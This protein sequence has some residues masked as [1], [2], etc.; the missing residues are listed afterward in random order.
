MNLWPAMSMEKVIM[1][2]CI[3]DDNYS[4]S[5]ESDSE[6]SDSHN[7]YNLDTS[8]FRMSKPGKPDKPGKGLSG[9]ILWSRVEYHS[10]FLYHRNG[11][12]V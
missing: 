2:I 6:D 10:L 8:L 4:E 12:S 3:E 11:N 7:D 5:E 9:K 1:M